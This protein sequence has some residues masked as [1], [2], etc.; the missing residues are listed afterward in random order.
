M[1]KP[2]AD[3]LAWSVVEYNMVGVGQRGFVQMLLLAAPGVVI[4]TFFLGVVMVVSV[5]IQLFSFGLHS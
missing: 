2:I 3:Q 4:S 1:M 5:S